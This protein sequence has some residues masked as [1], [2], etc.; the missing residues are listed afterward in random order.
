MSR[1]K[2]FCLTAFAILAISAVASA[3]AFAEYHIA[4]ASGG[5]VN[6]KNTTATEL[7]TKVGT[8]KCSTAAF[9]GSLATE[10]AST[11]TVHPEFSTCA[12]AGL[13]TTVTTTGCNFEFQRPNTG[14]PLTATVKIVCSG[15]SVIEIKDV[16]A[17]GCV[18][19][20]G[21]QGPLAHVTFTNNPGGTVT[22]HFAVTGIAYTYTAQCPNSGGVGGSA[23]DGK[24]TGTALISGSA[25]LMVT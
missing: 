12:L 7:F 4:S 8:E 2:I 13:K 24:L 17:L 20:I 1:L 6:G 5:T 21:S 18:I 22:V 15:S 23:I 14:P 19:K 25:A 10:T 3:S 9:T 11:L 16:A